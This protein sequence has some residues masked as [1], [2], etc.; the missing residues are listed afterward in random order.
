MRG[1]T[2]CLKGAGQR[3]VV[4]ARSH[5]RSSSLLKTLVE[6]RSS[7]LSRP[8]G[9]FHAAYS[10]DCSGGAPFRAESGSGI[11]EVKD[12]LLVLARPSYKAVQLVLGARPPGDWRGLKAALLERYGETGLSRAPER[13]QRI[14]QTGPVKDHLAKFNN[15]VAGC[16]YIV[17]RD[18]LKYYRDTEF[19]YVCRPGNISK[20]TRLAAYL[21]ARGAGVTRLEP[22]R[23]KVRGL[24]TTSHIRSSRRHTKDGYEH[25]RPP[26]V[27]SYVQAA[28]S[29][30]PWSPPVANEDW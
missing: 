1:R 9:V 27:W 18:K 26:S 17:Q 13:L 12:R 28:T 11:R 7:A 25:R 22:K 10:L 30:S 19:V 3:R 23:N 15:S 29:L 5:T 21:W 8:P 2:F 20:A 24:H 14:Q 16:I 4:A 6:E